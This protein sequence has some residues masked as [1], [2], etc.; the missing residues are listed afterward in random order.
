M[1]F[2]LDQYSIDRD[3]L[4]NEKKNKSD[5]RYYSLDGKTYLSYPWSTPVRDYREIQ[6]EKSPGIW[7][8]CLAFAGRS[9]LLCTIRS[10]RDRV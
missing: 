5:D 1:I 9:V 3:I 7:R 8:S 10:E 4:T 2:F 6:R